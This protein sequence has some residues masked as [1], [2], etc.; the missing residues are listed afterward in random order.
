MMREPLSI[1][2]APANVV[3]RI[4]MLGCVPLFLLFLLTCLLI[5]HYSHPIVPISYIHFIS[6]KELKAIC[7]ALET[8]QANLRR[9]PRERL[10]SYKNASKKD[11][12]AKIRACLYADAP[13]CE[14]E[15]AAALQELA[16]MT[17]NDDDDDDE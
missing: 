16:E 12:A 7:A 10:R 8:T 15:D 11:L 17:T 9:P 6:A 2:Q 1:F 5:L 4:F 3:C 14:V 13:A